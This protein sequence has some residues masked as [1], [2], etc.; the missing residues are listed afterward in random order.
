[1]S[2]EK[3]WTPKEEAEAFLDQCFLDDPKLPDYATFA[4]DDYGNIS[5]EFK[6]EFTAYCVPFS[7]HFWAKN[8]A[9]KPQTAAWI[10][11]FYAKFWLWAAQSCKG[12]N[13]KVVSENETFLTKYFEPGPQ[14]DEAS[15]D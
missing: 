8:H 11:E 2:E 14:P 4:V 7:E 10:N 6:I 3:E 15:N 13:Y 1:M 12:T 5:Y 9:D